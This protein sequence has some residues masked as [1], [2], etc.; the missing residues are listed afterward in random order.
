[1]IPV[2]W[3]LEAQRRIQPHI[4]QTPLSHD[5]ELDVYIKWENCQ[6]TGS[7]KI[8]GA[9]NKILSLQPWERERGLVAASAGNHGQGVALAAQKVGASAIVFASEHAVSSKVAA[10]R[11]LGAQVCLVRG[12]YAE[13]EKAGLQFAKEN[14]AC[15]VS[16]YNDGMVIA[17]QGTL[18]LEAL[19]QQPD[20]N[21]AAWITPVGGGGL[22]SGI[23]E[24]LAEMAPAAAVIGAQTQTSPFMHAIFKS[25]SQSGVVEYDSLADGLSGPVEDGS[26]T[27]AMVQ[28]LVKDIILVS[29]TDVS[30]AIAYAWNHYHEVIEGA[31]AVTLAA[32]ITGKIQKRPVVVIISGG[33]IQPEIHAQIIQQHAKV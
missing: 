7:F 12:G 28:K 4:L 10:M 19:R 20:L 18:A 16:P 9:L 15:W 6:V 27:I 31:A 21:Q 17:G 11:Q 1:M 2:D 32:L 29:E 26:I 5:P 24:A 22:A 3:F 25:G 14:G 13:A 30:V 33:N 8:R 23:G